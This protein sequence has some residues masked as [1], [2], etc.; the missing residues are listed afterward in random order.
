VQ[1]TRNDQSGARAHTEGLHLLQCTHPPALQVAVPSKCMVQLHIHLHTQG[2]DSFVTAVLGAAGRQLHHA[3]LQWSIHSC[4]VPPHICMGCALVTLVIR[5]MMGS[6]LSPQQSGW[7]FCIFIRMHLISLPSHMR[8][9]ASQHDPCQKELQAGF[10]M[11]EF[12]PLHAPE[13]GVMM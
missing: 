9:H 2:E 11:Q 10:L 13:Q 1:Q 7:G 12:L 6:G 5:G 4:A 8:C 3:P